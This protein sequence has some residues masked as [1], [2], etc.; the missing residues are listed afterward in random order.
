MQLTN[1]F[2]HRVGKVEETHCDLEKR[3]EEIIQNVA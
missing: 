3:S 2:N 1:G